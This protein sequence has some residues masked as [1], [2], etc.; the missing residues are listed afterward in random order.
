VRFGG[1][2]V[3][4]EV[5]FGGNVTVGKGRCVQFIGEGLIGTK[6]KKRKAE[7]FPFS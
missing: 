4:R 7:G 1:I 3:L 5:G 2:R 6:K